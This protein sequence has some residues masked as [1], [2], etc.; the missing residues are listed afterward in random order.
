[1]A[2]RLGDGLNLSLVSVNDIKEII[3]TG[4]IL[5]PVYSFAQ[6]SLVGEID[7]LV[8]NSGNILGIINSSGSIGS[9]RALSG[10]IGPTSGSVIN[11]YSGV[12][13][14]LV[15]AATSI[16]ANIGAGVSA[17]VSAPG[18]LQRVNAPTVRGTIVA[19]NVPFSF[20]DPFL[21]TTNPLNASVW[22]KNDMRRRI[23]TPNVV[24]PN[25]V[26]IGGQ[27][28]GLIQLNAGGLQG[29]ILIGS[30]VG[31]NVWLGNVTVGGV[32]LSP[33]PAYEFP[34]STW[35]G[36]QVAAVP[37]NHYVADSGPTTL[38]QGLFNQGG[39]VTAT[40]LEMAFYGPVFT[41][42]T[43]VNGVCQQT[44]IPF[45]VELVSPSGTATLM[46]SM[47]EV[48][49]PLYCEGSVNSVSRFVVVKGK[50]NKP[51]LPTPDGWT[52]RVNIGSSSEVYCNVFGR[53]DPGTRVR[54]VPKIVEFTLLPDCDKD[55]IA[56]DPM[57]PP[58]NCDRWGGCAADFNFDA[59]LDFFDQI[60]FLDAYENGDLAADFNGDN[61]LDFFDIDSFTTAFETGCG[62]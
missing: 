52:Y 44:G 48:S 42:G 62:W 10:R 55:G 4:D 46:N 17:S 41:P 34:S 8:S 60:D 29:S 45:D 20:S 1:V 12:N 15:E 24:I 47:V 36:G 50:A 21:T 35:G 9:V 53:I 23:T 37:F 5:A 3:V 33:K 57:N 49:L 6:G 27:S 39:N 43:V 25:Q 59:F 58:P 18:D 16:N 32:T 26:V 19:N 14:G 38:P 40:G 28:T 51:M 2:G 30:N 61:F 7:T 31:G 56:D 22:I 11:V 54:V 13:I